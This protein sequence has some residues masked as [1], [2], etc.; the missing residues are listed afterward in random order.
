MQKIGMTE[1]SNK[2]YLLVESI[3]L[4]FMHSVN[5]EHCSVFTL[6]ENKCVIERKSKW[7]VKTIYSKWIFRWVFS[8]TS[9]PSWSIIL[10]MVFFDATFALL[11]KANNIFQLSSLQRS[12]DCE[13]ETTVLCAIHVFNSKFFVLHFGCV[14]KR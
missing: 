4:V 1:M 10:N 11:T 6:H 9:E 14:C 12:S 5:I 8:S 7:N 3:I 13:I 2:I